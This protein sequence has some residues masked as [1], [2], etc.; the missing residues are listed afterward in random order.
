[1]SG[2]VTYANGTGSLS[3]VISN[4]AV[5]ANSRIILSIQGWTESAD[6]E[7]PAIGVVSRVPGTSFTI[8][9]SEIFSAITNLIIYWEIKEN[10]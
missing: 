5:T 7:P 1:M 2:T 9:C 10:D 8:K 3:K 4:T 6:A